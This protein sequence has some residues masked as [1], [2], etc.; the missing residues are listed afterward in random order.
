MLPCCA[1]AKCCK[2]SAWSITGGELWCCFTT[3]LYNIYVLFFFGFVEGLW[4]MRHVYLIHRVVC[5]VCRVSS[6]CG[7]VRCVRGEGQGPCTMWC[8]RC[9][10]HVRVSRRE[11]R[12]E[13]WDLISPQ[14]ICKSLP[15]RPAV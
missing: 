2:G 7:R 1:C 4:F 5:A 3:A 9:W 14:T 6:S 11:D 15:G 8:W 13:A 12:W 10:M